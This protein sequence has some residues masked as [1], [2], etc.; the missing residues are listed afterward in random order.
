M[1]ETY[2]KRGYLLEKYRLFH[3]KDDRGTNVDYHYH[4]FYKLV[5]LLSGSGSYVVEGR[6][7]A[8]SPGDIILVGSRCVHKPEFAS[9][10]SY[11][12]MIL[13]ISPEFLSENSDMEYRL[14]NCFSGEKGHVLRPSEEFRRRFLYQMLQLESEMGGAFPGRAILSRCTL[15]RALVEVGQELL[16]TDT[17]LPGPVIPKDSK[18]L[19]ILRFLDGNLTEDISIDDLAS[20]SYI[21][22]YHMMRRFREETGTS[23]HTYLSDKRLLLARDMIQNGQSATD[24]CFHSG[25]RSYSAFSRAYG[26]LFGVTPTGRAGVSKVLPDDAD[27]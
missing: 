21:S 15:L 1:E 11:E 20:R 26:K 2:E 25:F 27:E 23:I 16:K 10:I 8:L 14:E 6:R 22:K 24:A 9:G 18:V 4:D 19:D 7:Y 5:F 17:E 3:L 13:Y 12:R